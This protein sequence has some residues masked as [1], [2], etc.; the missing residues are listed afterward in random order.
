MHFKKQGEGEKTKNDS[1]LYLLTELNI[2]NNFL[3][4]IIFQKRY[5][6]FKIN[7]NLIQQIRFLYYNKSNLKARTQY[8]KIKKF[9]KAYIFIILIHSWNFSNSNCYIFSHRPYPSKRIICISKYPKTQK[10]SHQKSMKIFF[11]A[12]PITTNPKFR[13]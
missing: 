6:I 12:K 5:S 8:V 4:I 1:V 7:K 10:L 9:K 13:H 3:F 2:T 11:T